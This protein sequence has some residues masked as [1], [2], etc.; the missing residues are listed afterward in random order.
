VSSRKNY[1]YFQLLTHS[2]FSDHEKQ[3]FRDDKGIQLAQFGPVA[4]INLVVGANNSGK[5]RLLRELFKLP[6]Y[7]YW[8]T[9]ELVQQLHAAIT[10]LDELSTV[11]TRHIEITEHAQTGAYADFFGW[12]EVS[13]ELKVVA[14]DETTRNAAIKILRQLSDFTTNV[15]APPPLTQIPLIAAACVANDQGSGIYGADQGKPSD[16]WAKLRTAIE[17]FLKKRTL[18]VDTNESPQKTFVPVLRS[19][20]PLV[21]DGGARENDDV[22]SRTT[23]E[24]Q[25]NTGAPLPGFL[26]TG[27]KLYEQ[28]H[29]ARAGNV[30]ERKNFKA[31]ERFIQT[32][33][34]DNVGD[35]EIVA[36]AGAKREVTVSMDRVEHPLHFLGDGVGGLIMLLYPMFIAAKGTYFFIEEPENSLHAGYQRLMFHAILHNPLLKEKELKVFCT[37]HSNHLLGLAMEGEDVSVFRVQKEEDRGKSYTRVSCVTG[38]AMNLLDEL[39]VSNTSVYL[40]KCSIWVEGPTDREHLQGYL[41]AYYESDAAAN[42]T[43]PIEGLDYAFLE[44]G[45]SLLSNYD[46]HEPIF[47]NGSSTHEDA[48]SDANAHANAKRI[49]T[50]LI[51]NRVFLLVDYDNDAKQE[52]WKP[53]RDCEDT[54]GKHFVFH[55]LKRREIENIASSTLVDSFLSDRNNVASFKSSASNYAE[56]GKTGFGEYLYTLT[57]RKQFSGDSGALA[58]YYKTK[59]AKRVREAAT[60]QTMSDDAQELTT[61]IADFIASHSGSCAFTPS[62]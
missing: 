13:R 49:A 21:S 50:R 1:G 55:A 58:N 30:D 12:V 22:F 14:L 24:L 42:V 57:G 62:T 56:Y 7:T 44:F 9:P 59:F 46:F 5:S 43:K 33:F 47:A 41:R 15:Q 48:A 45:G 60:W 27:L 25:F 26:N 4:R 54:S 23:H 61:R 32:T 38:P 3:R 53:L 20:W 8:P 2:E 35:F 10:A 52:R 17:P 11:P 39:G 51:T 19:A 37:T 40:A 6:N 28:M 29:G 36:R 31:F 16:V 34:F 18:A